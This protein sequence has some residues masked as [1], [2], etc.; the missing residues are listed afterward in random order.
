MFDIP[1]GAQAIISALEDAGFEAFVV[2]GCVRD[3]LLGRQPHDWDICT[4]ARPNAVLN[5][6]K[7][8]RIVPTGLQHGTLTVFS[9]NFL[10]YEVT[11]YR[12]DG[13]YSDHRRPD[14][15]EFTTDLVEDLARRDFTV[16]AMAYNKKTGVIDPFG[17]MDDLRSG[18]I[19]CVGNPNDRFNEDA[20]RI[21]RALRFSAIYGF[22]I[23]PETAASIHDNRELLRR[24]SEERIQSELRRMIAGKNALPVL[25]A[26]S[27]V[28]ATIIPEFK[29]CI[30]FD[31]KNPYHVYTVYEHIM[32]AMDN[33]KGDDE[34][35]R[36]ALFLH[37]IGKPDCFTTDE[38]GG[39]FHG[40]G[41]ISR[42]K[43]D[44]ILHRLRF[45]T[46]T[47]DAVCELI[48]HHDAT[49]EPTRKT[50]R[51]WLN[52]LGPEQFLRL[53]DVR[54]ADI[55]AHSPGTQA[56]RIERCN[57]LRAYYEELVAEGA[58]F[59]LKNLVINGRDVMA[60]GVPQGREVGEVLQK[61]LGAV[62]E[63]EVKND[64]DELIRFAKSLNI[65]RG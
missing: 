8:Q 45:D 14:S 30:G 3:S 60:L 52:K 41:F 21:L 43:A 64:R 61:C 24:I 49:I 9:T 17:G 18:L 34:I 36:L 22:S 4:S 1:V 51:R 48:Y 32:R 57:A 39:H 37:D 7:E 5:V 44:A 55:H 33:Y 54:M 53:L 65:V 58:C 28:I 2:G 63:E 38:R 19:R 15:V 20:L 16:N 25:L 11:T 46:V 26:Y 29:N 47:L 50:V 10:P 23:E 6:F 13:D 12:I 59:S 31:Q 62:M 42:N 40:H 27:D 56:S 35:V